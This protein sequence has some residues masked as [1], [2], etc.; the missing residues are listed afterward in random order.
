[1]YREIRCLKQFGVFCKNFQQWHFTKPRKFK[2]PKKHIQHIL[3]CDL[4][5]KQDTEQCCGFT[6]GK[7]AARYNDSK[8]RRLEGQKSYQV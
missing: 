1:M 3:K 5:L 2:K 7:S 8:V 4:N 6:T